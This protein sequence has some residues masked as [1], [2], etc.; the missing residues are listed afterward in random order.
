MGDDTIN[1]GQLNLHIYN[2]FFDIITEKYSFVLKAFNKAG[3][4]FWRFKE[5]C[6]CKHN[7]ITIKFYRQS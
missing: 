2:D 7:S 6:S 5:A 4:F 3:N 1:R